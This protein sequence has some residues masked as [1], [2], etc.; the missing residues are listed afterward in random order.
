[1][2]TSTKKES[3]GNSPGI[4]SWSSA[5]VSRRLLMSPSVPVQTALN[6]TPKQLV[7]SVTVLAMSFPCIATFVILFKELGLK[8]LLASTGIMLAV[9][10]AAGA[11]LK[12]ILL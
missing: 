4:T 10:L 6:L 5:E 11:V 12:L 7:V 1:M 3:K 9:V 2:L 8:R